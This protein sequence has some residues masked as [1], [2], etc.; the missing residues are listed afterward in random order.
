MIK[1]E[2]L[3]KSFGKSEIIKGV[4]AE[5]K[6]GEIFAI[7]GQSGAGKST[8]LRCINGLENY[9]S[10][11]L[12]VAGKEVADLKGDEVREFRKNIGMIFQHFAL[13][14]RKTVA[15]NVAT[16]LRFWKFEEGYI[17]ERV[18]ELLELVGLKDKA[19]AYPS[20]LSGGQKQRVAIA[21]ALALKPQILLSDEA[22]SALDPN[23]TT[24]I[25]NLLKEINRSLGITIVLVTHEMEVVKSIANRAMLLKHGV[26]VG[27]GDIV[28]L[29]LHPDEHMKEFLG[30]EEVLPPNNI[31]VRLF[32]PPD[33]AFDSIITHMAHELGINFNIVWGKLERLDKSV[34]GSL[35]IN[36]LPTQLEA[37]EKYIS[38]KG[39]IYEVVEKK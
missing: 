37:V 13:M 11:S 24:Q 31:N 12:K 8:L 26:V 27:S 39:V 14:S 6:K 21:R 16:P 30:E 22:T 28:E 3:H 38:E 25:L 5:I 1:I 18:A 33:V 10:G 2:N 20:E 4:S 23:T 35:V 34:V 29:F 17:K 15:E 7:V 19:N 32:F 9:Q 36:V